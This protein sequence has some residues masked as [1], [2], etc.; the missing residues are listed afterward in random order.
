MARLIGKLSP[1]KVRAL[2]AAA[3][4]A[5]AAACGSTS[6]RA[7]QSLALPLHAGRPRS[8]DG[9][10]PVAHDRAGRSPGARDGGAAATPRRH[11]SDREEARGARRPAAGRGE[12]RD[13]SRTARQSISRRTGPAGA[14]QSMPRNGTRRLPPTPI[15]SS[16]SCPSARST[17]AHVTKLL[18]PIWTTKPETACRVRGRIEAVLDYATA[19][20]WRTGENPARWHGHLENVL[21]KRSKVRTVEHHAALPWR[22]IGAF[23]ATLRSRTVS[24]RWRCGSRS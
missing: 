24:P 13:A 6:A 19:H 3:S 11:R 10:W 5:T 12:R 18:E 1:A 4:T 8:G 14:T 15:R 22:E 21:P 7:A 17:P 23:M 20:G 2:K 9:P 16:A